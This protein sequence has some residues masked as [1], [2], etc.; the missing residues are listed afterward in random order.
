MNPNVWEG[1]SR[2]IRLTFEAVEDITG[3]ST[4]QLPFLGAVINESNLPH[5]VGLI[6]ALRLY[7][8]VAAIQPRVTPAEGMM[9]AGRFI[10]GSVLPRF[11]QC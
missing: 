7:P 8:P 10:S 6:I 9:I 5:T 2:D 11:Y 4:E 3:H 1:L